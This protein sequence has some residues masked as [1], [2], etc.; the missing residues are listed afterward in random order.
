M[1]AERLTKAERYYKN[2]IFY[3]DYMFEPYLCILLL[4]FLNYLYFIEF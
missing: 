2:Y 4:M 3:F 1:G